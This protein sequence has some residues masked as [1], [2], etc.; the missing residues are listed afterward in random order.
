MDNCIS[1]TT[2]HGIKTGDRD[3]GDGLSAVD[4]INRIR[5]ILREPG[6]VV[7]LVGL[8]GVGKTR[9]CEALFDEKIGKASLD[10]SLAIYT[11]VAEGPDPPPVGLAS[12]L[13]AARTRA[14]LVIDNCPFELH[15]QLTN[16]ARAKDSKISVI[17]V[18]YDIRDDQPEG[19]EVFALTRR[20][21]P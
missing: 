21:S 20:P 7:R 13:I 17:T 16:V 15:R 8:S 10:P 2:R 1:S 6:H 5:A 12:D 3:D 14:I 19:T 18:E 4:G 9:L 11:N